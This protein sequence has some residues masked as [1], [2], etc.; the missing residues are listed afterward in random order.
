MNG[1]YS[2]GQQGVMKYFLTAV[3]HYVSNASRNKDDA[4]R[5]RIEHPRCKQTG[6]LTLVGMVL[7][8]GMN[9]AQGGAETSVSHV[10]LVQLEGITVLSGTGGSRW[11]RWVRRIIYSWGQENERVDGGKT[12]SRSYVI[13]VERRPLWLAQ[14][15]S[16]Q[17][18]KK[19][20]LAR[21]GGMKDDNDPPPLWHWEL[22]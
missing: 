20:A 17:S 16:A 6:L 19:V 2:C 21:P 9:L 13:T 15:L 12:W 10:S 14:S 3:R 5:E 7:L 18:T 8:G 1:L 4:V 22:T 11:R